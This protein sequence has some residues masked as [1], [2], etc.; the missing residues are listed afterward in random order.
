MK[1][2]ICDRCGCRTDRV[3][4]HEFENDFGEKKKMKLCW[5]CDFDV[6]NGSDYNEDSFEIEQ[7]REEEDY[8]FDP[9]NNPKPA[10]M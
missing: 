7:R 2:K 9:I 3:Y 1:I 5:D 8:L 4:P 10:W 6:I